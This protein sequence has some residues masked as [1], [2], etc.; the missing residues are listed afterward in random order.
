ML[1]KP[2]IIPKLK[3]EPT[4]LTY[5]SNR[6]GS[7]L[8]DNTKSL[9]CFH[10]K[11]RSSQLP[12]PYEIKQEDDFL[13]SPKELEHIESKLTNQDKPAV[14]FQENFEKAK[15]HMNHIMNSNLPLHIKVKMMDSIRENIQTSM[16]YVQESK[17]ILKEKIVSLEKTHCYTKHLNMIRGWKEANKISRNASNSSTIMNSTVTK[18]VVLD[19]QPRKEDSLGNSFLSLQSSGGD[20]DENHKEFYE[21]KNEVATLHDVILRLKQ[22]KFELAESVIDQSDN[23]QYFQ[24]LMQE[25][26]QTDKEKQEYI[27]DLKQRISQQSSKKSSNI[28]LFSPPKNDENNSILANRGGAN[29]KSYIDKNSTSMI[30]SSSILEDVSGKISGFMNKVTGK[31]PS[32]ITGLIIPEVPQE[33]KLKTKLSSAGAAIDRKI[34]NRKRNNNELNM[35]T[36]VISY[37]PHNT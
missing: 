7:A 8:P 29:D 3:K 25:K 23:I 11:V 30:N 4:P 36:N 15:E 19:E 26:K 5:Q 18:T 1:Q 24:A 34:L 17:K 10:R 32:S 16:N 13:A 31:K 37:P 6:I 2:I 14:Q 22:D 27:E 28:K 9:T 21:L 20:L 33:I 35:I 12:A